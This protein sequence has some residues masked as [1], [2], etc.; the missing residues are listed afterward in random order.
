MQNEMQDKGRQA[1]AIEVTPEMILAGC[2]AL[3]ELI[4]NEDDDAD[5]VRHV[6]GAMAFLMV[7]RRSSVR[8]I[9]DMISV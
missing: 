8:S 9:A 5:I 1:D 6:Y 2:K 3:R 4:F 7:S